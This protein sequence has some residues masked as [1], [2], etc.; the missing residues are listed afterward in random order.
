MM[1]RMHVR[2][3]TGGRW[4]AIQ[5]G[6]EL[7]CAEVAR[8]LQRYL[9]DE[10]DDPV[11]VAALTAHLDVCPPCGYEAETYRMIKSRLAERCEPLESGSVDRLRSFGSSLMRES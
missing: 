7:M 4:P 3:M 1:I 5:P 6:E 10:I 2:R 9:D 11:V 8:L